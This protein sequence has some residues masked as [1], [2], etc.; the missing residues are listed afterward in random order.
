[1][2]ATQ[3]QNLRAALE[4]V[5]LIL[6]LGFAAIVVAMIALAYRAARRGNK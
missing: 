1:V 3:A 6:G 4:M 5:P 2:D